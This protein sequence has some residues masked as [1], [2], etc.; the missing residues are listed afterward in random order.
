M[1]AVC[2]YCWSEHID[3]GCDL[4][5]DDGRQHSLNRSLDTYRLKVMVRKL[6]EIIE[7]E[8]P[9]SDDRYQFAMNCLTD[10]GETK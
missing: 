9:E 5:S 6:C 3:C 4:L 7:N 10:V 8:Y 2:N 1:S